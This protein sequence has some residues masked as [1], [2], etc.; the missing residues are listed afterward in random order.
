MRKIILTGSGRNS[1]EDFYNAFLSAVGAPE[2]HGHNLDALN[3]SIGTGSIN[4][5]EVPYCVRIRGL[6]DMSDAARNMGY[7]FEKLVEDLK[8]RGVGIDLVCE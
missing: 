4:E 6:H 2:W 1:R 3:D 8:A 7:S 5:L